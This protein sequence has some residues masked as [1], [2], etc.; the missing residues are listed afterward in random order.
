MKLLSGNCQKI[1][2]PVENVRDIKPFVKD[3]VALCKEQL[4]LYPGA[5]AIA[6]SQVEYENPLRF[7]VFKDGTVVINPEIIEASFQFNHKEGC[8][9]FPNYPIRNTKRFKRVKV[10]YLNIK[11][12]EVEEVADGLRACIFQHEID[13][14]NG[15]TV[16]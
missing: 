8:M 15:I 10:R 11:G 16:Y 3:M 4:G 9:S 5:H 13:H 7:F 12:K 1:S 2:Q 6:H 14:F